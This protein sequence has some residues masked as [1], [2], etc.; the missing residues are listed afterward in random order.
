MTSIE[1][2]SDDEI[3]EMIKP[4]FINGDIMREY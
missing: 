4:G 1:D 2:Y 3:R